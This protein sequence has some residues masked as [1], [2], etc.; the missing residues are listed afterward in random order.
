MRRF[1]TFVAA[2]VLGVFALTPVSG[3]HDWSGIYFGASLGGVWGNSDV[4]A[5]VGC[6]ASGYFCT[7]IV[8]PDNGPAVAAAGAGSFSSDSVIGGAQAGYNAQDKQF[9]YGFEIDISALDLNGSRLVAGDYDVPP[10]PGSTFTIGAALSTNWLFTAR[11]RVGWSVSNVLVYATGGLALTD[12][13]VT[14]TF[15]DDASTGAYMDASST[16]TKVGYTVGGGVEWALT[17]NWSARGEY[18]YVD[19]GSVTAS[20]LASNAA[21]PVVGAASPIDTS[22][23]LSAHIA[24]AGLNYRFDTLP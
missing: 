19:F 12:L 22:V 20:G 17:G 10:L 23:D 14:S 24:R 3:A 4:D 5:D 15:R 11:G 9:V 1:L 6:P 13:K 16:E 8:A 2:C 18:L 7:P 21:F